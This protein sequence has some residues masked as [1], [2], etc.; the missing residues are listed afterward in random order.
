MYVEKKAIMRECPDTII[1]PLKSLD[2]YLISI[3]YKKDFIDSSVYNGWHSTLTNLK[4]TTHYIYV[5]SVLG[6]LRFMCGI[7]HECYLPVLPICPHKEFVPYIFSQEEMGKIFTTA[8]KCIVRPKRGSSTLMAIPALIRLLYSTGMRTGEA[9]NIKNKDID[10]QRH[11]IVLNNTKNNCQRFAPINN[12]LECVLKQYI[13]FRNK[14]PLKGLK[15]P[16]SH[17]FVSH[18]GKPLNHSAV[19]D[20][21]VKILDLA[22]IERKRDHNGPNL[23]SLRHTA[24][25]HALKK[26]IDNGKD[27][28]CCLPILSAFMG[29]KNMYDTESYIHLT[30]E[31]FPEIVSKA[32]LYDT[33]ICN[34]IAKAITK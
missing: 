33:E 8:D 24:C 1:G 22:G 10:F 15:L 29:H 20:H 11:I 30:V 18:R 12:S 25:M 3:K 26:M 34:V 17:L 5:C 16:D 14:I 13:K 23:H 7:G 9:L 32:E 2:K 21:F 6:F 28:Y 31:L 27:M 4:P 19:Y